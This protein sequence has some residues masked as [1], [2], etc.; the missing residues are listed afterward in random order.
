MGSEDSQSNLLEAENE[1]NSEQ[2]KITN[3]LINAPQKLE[4]NHNQNENSNQVKKDS[5]NPPN[6]LGKRPHFA[7]QQ[8]GNS[9]LNLNQNNNPNN[10]QNQNNNP[11][12]NQNNNTNN[13]QNSTTPN[14]IK[15]TFR[16]RYFQNSSAHFLKSL[17]LKKPG[18]HQK[19][20]LK[21]KDFYKS[22]G[23]NFLVDRICN[24]S[25]F[26]EK[27]DGLIVTKINY[28]YLPGKSTGILKWKPDELNS[29]DFIVTNSNINLQNGPSGLL[30]ENRKNGK[31]YE[32]YVTYSTKLMLFDFFYVE[33]LELIK[34][35]D[36]M[37]KQ[38]KIIYNWKNQSSFSI[39]F[40]GAYFE[41]VYDK[42]LK[43]P[44]FGKLIS[45]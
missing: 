38:K 31:L 44:F 9:N 39:P 36:G 6:L 27:N 13:N 32:L 15:P 17:I 4:E 40:Y 12:N 33:D 26:K 25:L 10:N 1:P 2:K 7:E 28:P 43:Q 16:S 14:R 45:A 20:K 18:L 23:V 30:K 34:R 21:T 19:I 5:S 22:A 35:L 37:M 29:V 41:M 3:D 42:H 11:N 24:L 8:N